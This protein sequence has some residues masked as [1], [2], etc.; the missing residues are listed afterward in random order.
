MSKPTI[1]EGKPQ[2]GAVPRILVPQPSGAASTRQAPI[3]KPAAMPAQGSRISDAVRSD[4]GKLDPKLAAG[5]RAV[6][7]RK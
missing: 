3:P 2:G 7:G 4:L 1:W 6:A 5:I